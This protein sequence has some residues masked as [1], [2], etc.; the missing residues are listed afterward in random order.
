MNTA[1]QLAPLDVPKVNLAL[2]KT[3]LAIILD[4]LEEVS[5]I[6]DHGL[7]DYLRHVHYQE[8]CQPDN[9]DNLTSVADLP[10]EPLVE[11]FD[12]GREFLVPKSTLQ[13]WERHDE[14]EKAAEAAEA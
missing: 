6:D 13:D 8:F 14:F 2:S 5:Y 9:S 11:C 1:Y 4:A 3:E 12:G 10:P 7:F